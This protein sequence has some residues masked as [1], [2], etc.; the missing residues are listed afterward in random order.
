MT[1]DLSLFFV[2]DGPRLEVQSLL[3]AASLRHHNPQ[4]RLIGYISAETR[5]NLREVSRAVYAATGVDLRDLPGPGTLWARPYPHGNKL[6]AA[7]E[8]RKAAVSVFLD[9]DMVAVGPL[10]PADLPGPGEVCVVPEGVASWGAKGDRWE[11]AYAFFG[12]PLPTERVT[13]IR[14][15][16]SFVPYFNAGFV[17]F[18]END[19][20]PGQ[21]FGRLWRDTASAFDYGCQIANK[22]PWLD[23]ITMP[24]AMARHGLRYRVIDAANNLTIS[25]RLPVD[26]MAPKILHYHRGRYLVPW[27]QWPG[28]LALTL[29]AMP[30]A[31]RPAF[32]TALDDSRFAAEDD[33]PVTD[34]DE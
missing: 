14:H 30:P 34:A 3:L 11:R 25:N 32:L 5:A 18:R 6:I 24:L 4:A 22:R 10:D 13:L 7:A 20:G 23:Q 31:L 19:P 29:D 17:A 15:G 2:I 26:G 16:R 21:S 33:P 28:V 12:L 9:T 1:A 27:P 8:P